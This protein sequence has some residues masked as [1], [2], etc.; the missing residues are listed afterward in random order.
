[1]V[2]LG[3]IQQDQ[4]LELEVCFNTEQQS[5]SVQSSLYR[6]LAYNI[7]HATHHMAIMQIAVKHCYPF[8]QLETSFGVA[9]STQ[10]HL[11]NVHA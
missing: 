2:K 3:A 10:V 1:M 7:E 11:N 8:V 6:E 9:F 4:I 5:S